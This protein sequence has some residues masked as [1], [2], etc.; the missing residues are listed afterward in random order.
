[1]KPNEAL[2]RGGDVRKNLYGVINERDSPKL[3]FQV[4]DNL[5]ISK[6]ETKLK[7]RFTPTITNELFTVIEVLNTSPVT[8]KLKDLVNE[9]KIG[10]FHNSGEVVERI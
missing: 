9:L 8:Y 5:K 1:M 7:H 6:Y 3:R 10:S 2:D 4:G